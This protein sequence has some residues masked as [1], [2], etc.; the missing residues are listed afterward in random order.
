M[1]LVE[2]RATVEDVDAFV[3]SLAAIG[4]AHD[5]AVQALDARYV[6][7]EAHVAQAVRLATR[8]FARGENVARDRAMEILLFAAGRRQIEEA[9]EMGVSEGEVPVVVAVDAA[10][11]GAE[12]ADREAAAAAAVREH[13]EPADTLGR[14][15]DERVRAFFDVSDRELAA[16]LGDLSDV[17]RERVA[18]LVVE[19]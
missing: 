2:G 10:D 19:R 15:D 16:T 4:D 3:E 18:L 9:L 8:A 1:E 17:V 7:D 13:L 11:E 14:F 12:A 6:V 5:V